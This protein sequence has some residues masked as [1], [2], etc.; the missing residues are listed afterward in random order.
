MKVSTSPQMSSAKLPEP[1]H[2][3]KVRDVYDLGDQ[4]LLVATDRV[5]A[6][7]CVLPNLIPDKGRILTG[8]SEFWFEKT[9]KIIG[10]HLLSRAVPIFLHRF[11]RT[12]RSKGA[13]C[14]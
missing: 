13:P 1:A 9:R 11:A 5:S 3:G 7:D 14:W 12:L 8:L 10:N 6:F 4:L 2:R